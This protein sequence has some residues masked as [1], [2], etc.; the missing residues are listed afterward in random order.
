MSN[1]LIKETIQFVKDEATKFGAKTGEFNKSY[2]FREN[3]SEDA[4]GDGGYFGFI[5]PDEAQSGAF[6]DFSFVI[7]PSKDDK[8]WIVT[9]GIGSLGFKNDYELANFPGLRRLFSKLIDQDGFCKTDLSDIE[10]SLPKIITGREEIA[11]IKKTIDSY[12][13]VLPVIQILKEPNSEIDRKKI[14]A[15]LA[16]YAKI[17]EWPTNKDHKKSIEEALR[18]FLKEKDSNDQEEVKNLL[19]ERKYV[20]LQGPPG[21]GKTR[22]AKKI[23]EEL[24]AETF[25]VQFHAETSY[26]DFIYGIRPSINKGELSYVGE[27]GVLIKAIK[28]AQ[29]LEKKESKEN[30]VLII[31]EIN[32]ANLS[33]VLGPL[34]YLF[35]YQQEQS[36][37]NIEIAPGLKISAIPKNLFV[38][39]TM[40]TAD[41]SLAVVDF[42]LRRRFAW[43]NL[44]PKEIQATNFF[45]NDFLE[46]KRIFNWYATSNEMA[47]Q[48]GQG[49]FIAESDDKM[50]NRIKYELRPLIKEY[51]QEGLLASAKEDLNNYFVNRIKIPL[52]E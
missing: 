22:L 18:D 50:V 48:P 1:T 7:M 17:R 9:L 27:E 23:S 33:N 41:R 30:V 34:F 43:Y 6:S 47:L 29:E 25:F 32:R 2:I 31:D 51:L 28:K 36:E 21:V 52:Y 5:S 20:V 39:A 24:I 15:F 13:K 35:E 11:G 49:Y 16:A 38:I 26:S 10:T 12:T 42:A 37:I 46:F 45:T 3:T 8:G 40:N 14:L 4:L 44:Y 19:L